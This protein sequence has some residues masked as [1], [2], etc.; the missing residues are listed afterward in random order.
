MR[1]VGLPCFERGERE[2]N[3]FSAVV[4]LWDQE[5]TYWPAAYKSVRRGD[6]EKEY[7]YR[8]YIS[9]HGLVVGVLW[10]L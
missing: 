9:R 4:T 3:L 10:A 2:R 1:F 8:I 6:D 5:T 7:I